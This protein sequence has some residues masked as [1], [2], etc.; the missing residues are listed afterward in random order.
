MDVLVI[1]LVVIAFLYASSVLYTGIKFSNYNLKAKNLWVAFYTPYVI[2]KASIRASISMLKDNSEDGII[3]RYF[4]GFF[5]GLAFYSVASSLAAKMYVIH[6]QQLQLY[7]HSF[8]EIANDL[9]SEKEK[10]TY[11][12]T[13]SKDLLATDRKSVV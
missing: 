3:I 9:D 2:Y 5:M 8:A 1:L 13:I 10:S 12:S 4:K 6:L 11:S 7:G